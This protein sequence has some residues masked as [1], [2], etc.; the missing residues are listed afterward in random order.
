ME[1]DVF[2][3]RMVDIGKNVYDT[4]DALR[5]VVRALA[6][7]LIR[8]E[9]NLEMTGVDDGVRIDCPSNGTHISLSWYGYEL[10]N[11]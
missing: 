5:R 1:E 7:S 4:I 8:S 6:S 9:S 2:L 10:N 3:R 11:S